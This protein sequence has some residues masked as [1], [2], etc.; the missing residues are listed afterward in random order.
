MRHKGQQGAGGQRR[1]VTVRVARWSATHPWRAIGMW[2]TFVA[3]CV[4]VG[5]A[6]GTKTAS[7]EDMTTGESS[8]ALSMIND[9]GLTEP[10]EENVLI[11]ARSG[12]LDA[13]AAQVA[14]SDAAQRLGAVPGVAEVGAPVRAEDGS[15]VLVPITMEGDPDTADER[16]QPLLDATKEVQEAHPDLRVEEVGDASIDDGIMKQVEE[17]LQKAELFS[18]PVTLVILLVAFGAIVAAGVPVLLALSSVVSAFGLAGLASHLV[19]S[20]DTINS[21]ILLIGM[22]VGVDY[23]L[24]YLKREREERAKGRGRA[25]AIEVAAATSGHSVVVSGMAVMVSMAGMYLAG[26]AVFSS[27]ATGAMLVVAASVLGSLTVLPA[28][29]AKLGRAVDRPRVPV[30]WRVANRPGEP[31]LWPKLLRPALNHPGKAL[32]LG[33]VGLV[34]LAMPALDMK[35]QGSTDESL[36]RSIPV[37]QSF[38]RLTDAFPSEHSSH[39]VV[40]QAPA[41]RA[42]EVQ[43]ALRDVVARTAEDDLFVGTGRAKITSSGDGTVHTIEVATPYAAG[44]QEAEDSLTE[45][46]ERIL[47][48]TV[49]QVPGAESAVGG[50][51]AEGVDDSNRLSDKMPYV[52]GF[53]LL[54]TFVMMTWTFR[55]VVVALSAVVLNSLSAAAAFGLLTV[56]FQNTWAEGLLNFHSTGSVVNWMP[57]FLFVVL[58]GLSM[59][60]HVFVVSRI[61]EAVQQG[62]PNRRAVERGIVTSAGVVSS[63]AVVMVSVFSIFA[64]M[65]LVEMK[66]MGVA[67]AAAILID[68][69][70]IRAVMLPSLMILLGR[71]NWWPSRLS[72]RPRRQAADRA[73]A[74]RELVLDHPAR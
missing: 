30:L 59:D 13:R 15:A 66:E 6:A 54:L 42:G 32:L 7:D 45:L 63:A 52:V 65:S 49:G 8:R 21:V 40:V 70:I 73:P 48:E 55:S 39:D 69:T 2:M 24:F 14:A 37:V 68:A 17:D 3:L 58:F 56:V 38:D 71:A 29:L 74:E 34:A 61:R 60:Y 43:T 31:R 64:V 22:A 44:E 41:E 10:A 51:V 9:A 28:L 18:L 16:V 23:S 4:V 20:V 1:P 19:P 57:L 72:R 12:T 36:P 47:P 35:L 25:D 67:L 46:R 62:L 33:G 27:L 50:M 5:G 11:T 53:V 26:H